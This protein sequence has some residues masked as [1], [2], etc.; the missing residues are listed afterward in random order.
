MSP[1]LKLIFSLYCH[2]GMPFCMVVQAEWASCATTTLEE[3]TL[4]GSET[5]EVPQ[6]VNCPS[7][8]QC[9]TGETP[10]GWV[11]QKLCVFLWMFSRASLLDQG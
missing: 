9:Q 1:P 7:L 2:K 11:K 10:L 4:E 5:E 6:S 3:Q 8:A